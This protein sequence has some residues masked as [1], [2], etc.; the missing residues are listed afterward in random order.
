MKRILVL[1]NYD[2]FTFNLVQIIRELT[3]TPLDV[4]RNDRIELAQVS[5]YERIVFSPG[6]GLP[7][8]AGIMAEIIAAFANE[9][10]MLGVCLGHQCIAEVFGATLVNLPRPVHG[11]ERET[12][13]IDNTDYLFD[14][15]PQSFP[16]GRYHSWVVEP[17]TV[18]NCLQ[19]TAID[20]EGAI[21]AIRHRVFNLRG[22]QFHPESVLT[23]CGR[24]ILENWIHG[25]NDVAS[26]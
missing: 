6:P 13:V 5:A 11:S 10:N 1:D 22:V 21:M 15:I 9:K 26:H 25:G 24:R 4:V 19:V 7:R 16:A 23:P 20:N 18:P 3:T 14:G 12:I 8:E 2:S 17:K